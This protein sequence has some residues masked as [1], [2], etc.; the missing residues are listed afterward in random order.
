MNAFS[1]RRL[2]LTLAGPVLALLV[3]FCSQ[4]AEHDEDTRRLHRLFDTHWE[5]QARRAPEAA[6][7]RGDYRY[8]D[9]WSDFSL[10]HIAQ[11]KKD[12]EAFLKR[13]EAI[14]TEGFS[15]QDRLNQQLMV[16]Q[17]KD[18]L[19]GIA[20][21]KYEMPIDQFSGA[22]LQLAQF[23]SALPY[24]STRHY[25]DYIA[26]LDR[27]ASVVRHQRFVALEL[28]Q[29]RQR[30]RAIGVVVDDQ[31][32]APR[33]CCGRSHGRRDLGRRRSGGQPYGELA[34]ASGPFAADMD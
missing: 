9:K 17:L 12:A 25:E 20:L 18:G 16:R 7:T 31:D 30:L 3:A 26:R 4:A 34:A 23:V 33:E 11:Q 13:F 6:T 24:D 28:Q 1:P 27:G 22:H 8:N 32:P 15:E 14:D 19:E 29:H 5:V 10:R 21:K 2:V